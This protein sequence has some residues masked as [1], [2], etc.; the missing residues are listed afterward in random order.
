MS[1]QCGPR[2]PLQFQAGRQVSR[3]LGEVCHGGLLVVVVVEC[4]RDGLIPSTITSAERCYKEY[5]RV[6]KPYVALRRCR[7]SGP[8]G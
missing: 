4:V 5:L 7:T 6:A 3:A 8:L 2:F 1:L